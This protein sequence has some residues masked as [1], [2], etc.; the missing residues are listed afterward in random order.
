MEMLFIVLAVIVGTGAAF[1]LVWPMISMLGVAVGIAALVAIGASAIG[2][3]F[4]L[5]KPAG[6]NQ[7][8]RQHPDHL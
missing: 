8:P 3:M 1:F 5:D 2:V 4:F 7:I 6:L